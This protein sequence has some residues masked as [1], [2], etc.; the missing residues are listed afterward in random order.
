M[1]RMEDIN[2]AK[3]EDHNNVGVVVEYQKGEYELAKDANVAFIM[4]LS[5]PFEDVLQYLYVHPTTNANIHPISS[6]FCN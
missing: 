4:Y 2:C 6:T 1:D 5:K 3:G